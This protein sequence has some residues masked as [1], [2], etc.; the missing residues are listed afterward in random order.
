MSEAAG[1][2]ALASTLKGL[3][4]DGPKQT[5]N[6]SNLT[7]PRRPG[8]GTVGRSI[9]VLANYFRVD[10]T[11]AFTGMAVHYDID[12]LPVEDVCKPKG[13]ADRPLPPRLCRSIMNELGSV[14]KWPS[15]WAFDG[16]KNLYSPKRI[17]SADVSFQIEAPDKPGETAPATPAPPRPGGKGPQGPRMFNVAIREVAV[18]DIRYIFSYIKDAAAQGQLAMCELPRDALQ[19]LDVIMS[20]VSSSDPDTI[21]SGKAFYFY[22]DKNVNLGGGSEAWSGYKQVRA[23][24]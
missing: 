8:F 11:P 21:S 10:P 5:Y 6:E 16:R 2:T 3:K 18:V 9:K 1:V 23:E 24:A 14:K 22:D 17:F 15:G 20:W 12:I 13:P 4:L 7:L 19:V